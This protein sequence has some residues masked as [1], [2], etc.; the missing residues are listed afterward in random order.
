MIVRASCLL[1]LEPGSALSKSI[2]PDV[3]STVQSIGL[4]TRS[5]WLRRHCSVESLS[6]AHL[7]F[8]WSSSLNQIV[9]GSACSGP[10]SLLARAPRSS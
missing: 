6:T 3:R 8:C 2:R 4:L 7:Q 1:R 5:G 10:S 9:A